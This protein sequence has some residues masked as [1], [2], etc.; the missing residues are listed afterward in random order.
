MPWNVSVISD[1][2]SLIGSFAPTV[3]ITF[4][5][6]V[7]LWFLGVRDAFTLAALSVLVGG[8]PAFVIEW[9]SMRA[10]RKRRAGGSKAP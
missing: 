10:Q 5:V 9:K 2:L 4:I 3:A 7:I 8:V 1:G 6:G